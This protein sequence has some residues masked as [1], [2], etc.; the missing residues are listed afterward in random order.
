MSDDTLHPCVCGRH[1]DHPL[2]ICAPCLTQERFYATCVEIFDRP[3]FPN[4]FEI[5]QQLMRWPW[6]LY[7][8]LNAWARAVD[9]AEKEIT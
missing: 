4:Q 5:V 6:T 7:E 8:A 1:T 9:V 2:G 3:E